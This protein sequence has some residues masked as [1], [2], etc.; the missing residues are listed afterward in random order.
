[1]LLDRGLGI[2]MKRD[3]V[4]FRRE[5]KK[6]AISSK[7]R[8]QVASRNQAEIRQVRGA[9]DVTAKPSAASLKLILA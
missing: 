1:M 9:D 2:F 5:R 6:A 8:L 4:R 3:K 7:S